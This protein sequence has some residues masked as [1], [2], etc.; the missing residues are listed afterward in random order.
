MWS[1]IP[2]E[3]A[4]LWADKNQMK[5]LTTSMGPLMDTKHA[6]CARTRKSKEQWKRYV[7]GASAIFAH[8]VTKDH[9]VTVLSKPPPQKLHPQGHS[10][11][12]SI[13]EPIL[14]GIHGGAPVLRI[15]MVHI[16]VVGAENYRY[17]VWPVNKTQSWVKK[18]GL[19]SI[20]KHYLKKKG[21]ETNKKAEEMKKAEKKEGVEEKRKGEEKRKAEGKKNAKKKEKKAKK[22]KKAEKKI[23]KA[24]KKKDKTEAKKISIEKKEAKESVKVEEKSRLAVAQKKDCG[25]IAWVRD[26]S[27][28][29][30][31]RLIKK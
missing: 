13:E 2:R 3:W 22:K 26:S 10:T 16:T 11:Y 8:H 30:L 6:S 21:K 28:G 19:C 17:Q 23:K 24:E 9:F 5:T 14:K 25:E 7:K 20:L 18:Y 15:D 31:V 29:R 12:Q 27:S 4:Q 1:G